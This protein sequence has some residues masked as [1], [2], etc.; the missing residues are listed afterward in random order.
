MLLQFTRNFG[1]FQGR[2]HYRLAHVVIYGFLYSLD[3][4]GAERVEG[5]MEYPAPPPKLALALHFTSKT[6][7]QNNGEYKIKLREY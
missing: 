7:A 2:F 5:G 1:K 4:F 3:K 6:C